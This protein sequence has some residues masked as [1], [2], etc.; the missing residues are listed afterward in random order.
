[1]T[2]LCWEKQYAINKFLPILTRWHLIHDNNLQANILLTEIVK[3]R[4]NKGIKCYEIKWNNYEMT[5]IEPL[6]AVQLRYSK[7]V[8]LFESIHSKSSNKTKKK[9]NFYLF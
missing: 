8:S 1:M 3:K 4:V 5:T 9:G 6:A 7:E 2:K